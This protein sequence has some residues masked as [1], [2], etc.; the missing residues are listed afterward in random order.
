[1][2]TDGEKKRKGRLPVQA[3][4]AFRRPGHAPC[5]VVVAPFAAVGAG[6]SGALA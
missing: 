1:M 4:A 3:Q 2:G 6:A 5:G